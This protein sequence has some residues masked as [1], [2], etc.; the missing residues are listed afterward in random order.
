MASN[1]SSD[2][3]LYRR[4]LRQARPYWVHIAGTFALDLLAAPLA[5]LTPLPLK[6][7]VDSLIGSQPLP[8]PL[9]RLFPGASDAGVLGLVAGL[10]VFTA[11]LVHLRSMASDLLHTYTGERLVLDFRARLFRHLQ[12]LSLSYHDTRGTSDSLYRIQ[13]DAPAIRRV[14]I[15]GVIPFIT[16]AATLVGMIAVTA[17]LDRQLAAVALAVAPVL[18]LLS[19]N[20]RRRLR[21]RWKEYK[22][23]DSGAMSIVQEALA[24]TRV[25]KA[26]GQ[27]EREEERFV[28]RA[29][30]GLQGQIQLAL[31]GGGFDLLIGLTLALGTTAVLTLGAL[32]IREDTL[33]LG[34]LLLVMAYLSQLYDPLE[35]I[36]KKYADLQ[37]SLISAER[38][39]E[40]LDEP[41]EVVQR[42][43]A[44]PLARAS[45]AVTFRNVS[46]AYDGDRSALHD[47]SFEVPAGSRVGIAGPT[48][49]GKTTLV[50]LLM[51]FYDPDAGRILLDGVDLRDYRLTDLRGQFA[52]V[53]QDPVLLSTSIAENIA[54]ARPGAREDE[55]AA[56]ARAACAHDFITRL[57]ESYRTPVGE[58]G[59]RLSGGERQRISLARAF[60]KDAP[61]LILDEPTS[62]VDT[63][64]EREIMEAMERLMQGRTTFIIAH[65]LTTLEGC[66]ALL[67]VEAGRV[68]V[69]APDPAAD[70]G[71]D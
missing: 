55:I 68:R 16:S 1:P 28:Q 43:G 59:M 7:V 11:L 64:T 4:L 34:S 9:A 12:R 46:F 36:S 29:G 23:L 27:E 25:V 30:E 61:L 52:M 3:T 70:F 56:A 5:L 15:D 44:R 32:H 49:A 66:D 51:R 71:A 58:R 53:L 8:G 67:S 2:L 10:V 14:A 47:V 20:G 42:P 65:R 31:I 37:S 21:G 22:Q 69:T 35:R 18:L 24:A 54:Y 40:L 26:F 41:P 60:L 19:R 38:A 57:P 45:G 48:G 39:F 17:R 62:A 63:A 6:I 33:T 50:S 13:Y